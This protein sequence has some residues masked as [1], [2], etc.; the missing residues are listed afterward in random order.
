M[1]GGGEMTFDLNAG[2]KDAATALDRD[3]VVIAGAGSGKTRMLTQR[4]VNAVVPGRVAGWDPAAVD[5][6]V[7]ITFTDKAAGE[8]AERVRQTL[9]DA[10][11][12]EDSRR[13]DSA[14]V[15]TI[16][17]LCSRLLRR[18]AVE[19]GLD[20][21]FDVADTVVAGNL[22]AEAFERATLG[23]ISNDADVCALLDAYGYARVFQ[24]A[25][26]VTRRLAVLGLDVR[27]VR[28]EPGDSSATL[29]PRAVELFGFGRAACEDYSGTA[30]T[31]SDYLNRCAELL[32]EALELGEVGATEAET[33]DA[34][35]RLVG[36][37][38]PLRSIMGLEDVSE[39][40][41]SLHAQLSADVGAAIAA[42]LA[43]GLHRLVGEFATGFGNLKRAAGVLD[44]DD[45]QVRAVDLLTRRPDIAK[46]YREHFRIVMIDEFQDTDALQ[47][48]LVEALSRDDLCTVGD[49]KQ[50][51]YG[52][53]GADIDV[54]REHRARMNRRNALEVSLAVN[55]RSHPQILAF[56]NA[57]FSS[58][59]YFDGDL[60]R[61]KPPGE[62]RQPQAADAALGAGPRVEAVFVDSSAGDASDGRRAEAS[63]IARRLAELRVSGIDPG[64][65]VVLVRRYTNA[66]LF[67]EALAEEGLPAIIV[68]GSRFFG[69]E[70]VAIMRALVRAIANPADGSAVGE[71]L[72]SEFCSVSD[73][74]LARL[75]LLS[76]G[77]NARSLWALLCETGQMI[78]G[79]DGDA[80][81]RLV[82]VVDDARRDVGSRSLG[83]VLLMAVE[84]AGYDLRLLSRGNA[85]RDAFANVLKFA[86]RAAAFEAGGGAGPSAFSAYMDSNERLGDVETPA[87]VADDGS[88]AVRIMSVHA[89]KGLEFPVVAVADLGSSG[90][91][92]SDI[93]RMS[94]S[95][96]DLRIALAPPPS[97]G[98]SKLPESGWATEFAE[99]DRQ[100]GVEEGERVLYVAFTRARDLLIASGA[101][102]LRPKT[103]TAA[104]N[105]LAKLSRLLSVAVPIDQP[106][107]AEVVVADL[108]T[109]VEATVRVRVIDGAQVLDGVGS[110]IGASGEGSDNVVTPCARG[111]FPRESGSSS[112][113]ERVSYSSLY[114]FE[115]CPLR[116]YVGEILHLS[117]IEVL[118][119]GAF[120]PLRFGSALH[121][122]LQ[123]VDGTGALPSEQRIAALGHQFE[124]DSAQ[125]QRL[126]DAAG[127][128]VAS[129]T[130]ARAVACERVAREMPFAL[131]IGVG[132]RMLVGSVDLYARTGEEALI[133]DY[134]SGGS[135]ESTDGLSARYRLQAACYALA[136]FADR[137]GRVEVVF[138]R[139]EVLE[140]GAPQ[141]I[142]FSF[143]A[144]HEAELRA[145]IERRCGEIDRGVFEP[146]KDRDE[147][148]CLG[149]PAPE[150]LCPN[151]RP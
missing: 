70:E 77:G 48:R 55:Y 76:D 142:R 119:Q 125:L 36:A 22:R 121:A 83:D 38:K 75:R 16:H 53:R 52:F 129:N 122:A 140:S 67:T 91:N 145:E 62:G 84:S 61:L 23:L 95:E 2:Q 9:R 18:H 11:G 44:F 101:M 120:D 90:R 147:S 66:H 27:D 7:A 39:A 49:E 112:L 143:D 43:R 107:D 88:R 116:Y 135:D 132:D 15:S 13:I 8:L 130:A 45:L 65:M 46:W 117:N 108:M 150:G 87:S 58:A 144:E 32:G 134:K 41:R 151:A 54:Y 123:L 114:L 138:V 10:G 28:I 60:L 113:P 33:L 5:E 133:I 57:V 127:R 1:R 40:S 103:P 99:A 47:L 3:V 31:P 21:L 24:A 59:E 97:E 37:Y 30:R 29:L 34:L 109:E 26:G 79:P 98:D 100:A 12:V 105:D 68:G 81:R 17:G 51:I 131:P 64:D 19:A 63:V 93:V 124:L 82:A 4:F 72:A 92:S 102:N 71:L 25:L 69:L 80:I 118:E 56:V 110:P 128:F 78:D 20:P 50:S 14:W 35:G 96:T 111:R 136:A 148:V 74:A 42:P 139:P 149:C 141:E 146:L 126:R 73:D 106:C 94:T 104:K 137:C 6:V 115:Q 89:S 85:G 86:R